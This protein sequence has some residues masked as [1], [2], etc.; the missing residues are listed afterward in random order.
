M[1]KGFTKGLVIGSLVGA[2]MSM[3]MNADMISGRSRRRMMK[4]GRNF[5]RKS[6]NLISD[7]IGMFR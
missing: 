2:S 7:V 4:T 3:M 1:H 5:L 6:G